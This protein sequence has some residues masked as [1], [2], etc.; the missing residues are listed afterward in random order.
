MKH[1]I[2]KLLL[3]TFLILIPFSL[4]A[5]EKEVTLEE[6]V[7]TATRDVQE[8][9]KVPSNVTVITSKEI[10]Q[11]NAQTV[12]DLMRDE[13]GVVVRDYYGTGKTASVDIRGF[14]E[15][16]PLN[17]LVL[18]DGRRV[19][20]IDLSGVDWTQIPLDQVERIEIVRGSGSVLYGDNAVGGVINIITK[21]PDKPLS[22]KAEGV[23]GSYHYN[24]ETGS[25]GGKWGP[26]S[27]ILHAGYNATEGYRDNGFLRTRDVGG[28]IIYDLNEDVRFD[29][30]GGFH[31]DKAG[32]PGGLSK[33]LAEMDRRATLRP[34]DYA[35]TDDGYIDLGMKAKVWDVGRLEFN[36][37]YREREVKDTFTSFSFKD[38]RNFITWGFTPRYIL[39]KP[40]G[41]FPNKLIL[42]FDYYDSDNDVDYVSVFFGTTFLNRL[43]VKQRS[44]GPYFLDEFSLL[45]NLLLSLGYRYQWVTYDFFQESPRGKD[46]L[47]ES[48]SAWTIGL[49]HLL[50]QKSSAFLSVKRSFRF[51]VT[52]ELIQ[53]FPTFQANPSM[54]PQ[55]GYHYEGG[56]RY[57]FTDQVEANVTL[58]WIDLEDEIFFNPDPLTFANQ[59]YPKT[60]RQG[61][62][63]GAKVTPFPW[64]SIWGNYCYTRAKLRG[65]DFSGKEIPGVP[66][67]KGSVGTEINFGKGFLLSGLVNVVCRRYYISDWAN[68][69]EKLDKYYTLD[70][71]L[72][73]TWKGLKVF[74]GVNNITNQKYEEW[75]VTNG[76]GTIQLLYPSP[77]R[78]FLGGISYTF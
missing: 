19:N 10:D 43:E 33:V 23:V 39:E 50:G 32:L 6:V 12:I 55:T 56:V 22:A 5:Q 31:R 47:R 62:E 25:V 28:K 73:Y 59:N 37:S 69:I 52:D 44:F 20:E 18:V 38:T 72:S 9:R 66:R 53:F 41:K 63:V 2:S 17:T 3:S 11:S 68:Q 65:G 78:N 70:G 21:K 34:D 36:L 64:F 61:I 45:D 8:I 26:L 16:G 40:L 51:P 29:L 58:F 74:F 67:N 27:A 46:K 76:T 48:E 49:D 4:W 14:G 7:V 15:T 30:S 13:A 71:R 24:K 35:E 42:G 54:K 77:E 1:F 60:R 57:A 75:G